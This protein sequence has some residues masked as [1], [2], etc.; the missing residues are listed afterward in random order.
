MSGPRLTTKLFADVPRNHLQQTDAARIPILHIRAGEWFARHA[1][2]NEAVTHLL[3][4]RAWERT[5]E[6]LDAHLAEWFARGEYVLLGQWLNALPLDVLHANPLLAL[7]RVTLA[8]AANQLDMAERLLNEIQTQI[9]T[10]S[11]AVCGEILSRRA[12][13]AYF[14]N[15]L[16]SSLAHANA[17]LKILPPDASRL[18]TATLFT[19]GLVLGALGRL[20]EM[21]NVITRVSELARAAGDHFHFF[22]RRSS[23]RRAALFCRA[24]APRGGN[25]PPC[26]CVRTRARAWRND[27][28][29]LAVFGFER[30]IV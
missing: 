1:L 21:L 18:R 6:L 19:Q 8:L 16:E 10:P 23:N 29:R 15:Q 13:I 17:A 20:P 24:G 27:A 25:V 11:P 28:G 9:E 5:A 12:S 26:D 2:V 4:A 3:A 14:R 7:E 30:H 22:V